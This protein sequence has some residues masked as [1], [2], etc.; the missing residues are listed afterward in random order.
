MN[1][2]A[3]LNALDLYKEVVEVIRLLLNFR[4]R[5]AEWN[6]C[7][8]VGGLSRA[9]PHEEHLKDEFEMLEVMRAVYLESKVRFEETLGF[10][11][12]LVPPSPAMVDADQDK[13]GFPIL[14]NQSNGLEI[15]SFAANCKK[16]L[17]EAWDELVGR[18]PDWNCDPKQLSNP[19]DWSF[20][21]KE[22]D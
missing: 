21:I 14:D 1:G 9:V 11:E 6:Y 17:E 16:E 8:Y 7:Y 20:A 10:L 3:P 12:E 5:E 2:F 22:P 4:D 18:N 13:P 15:P 19:D